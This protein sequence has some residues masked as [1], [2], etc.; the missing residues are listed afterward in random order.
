MPI[1]SIPEL[2][3]I[4]ENLQEQIKE[5]EDYYLNEKDKKIDFYKK[6]ISELNF[7]IDSKNK[8]IEEL[9]FTVESCLNTINELKKLDAEKLKIKVKKNQ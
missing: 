7:T 5:L 1:S 2:N 6:T 3:R 4:I 8:E 9:N